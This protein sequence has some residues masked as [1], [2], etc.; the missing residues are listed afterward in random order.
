MRVT[1]EL[2]LELRLFVE[3]LTGRLVKLA[4][5]PG[6]EIRLLASPGVIDPR[7]RLL[8][9]GFER[10]E[11]GV[12]LLLGLVLDGRELLLD[13]FDL[14]IPLLGRGADGFGPRAGG[15]F[16][17]DFAGD[18][19]ERR[20]L[21]EEAEHLAVQAELVTYSIRMALAQLLLDDFGDPAAARAKL[22]ACEPE[23]AT[24]AD[25]SERREWAELMAQCTAPDSQ[26]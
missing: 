9:L 6:G 23:L 8:V 14:V 20:E 25:E 24:H 15:V 10:L 16:V 12:A 4:L 19:R 5:F 2:G 18:P 11:L 26:I 7:D 21:Y 22:M 13:A 1:L 17:N 3:H